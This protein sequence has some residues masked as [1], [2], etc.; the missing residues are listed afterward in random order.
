MIIYIRQDSENNDLLVKMQLEHEDG[1]YITSRAKEMTGTKNKI[2]F[3]QFQIPDKMIKELML[4]YEE[5]IE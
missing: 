2:H 3:I 1:S 4:S 5:T